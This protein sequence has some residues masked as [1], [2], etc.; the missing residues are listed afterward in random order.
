MDYDVVVVGCGVA[1]LS[2]ALTAVEEGARVAVLER[3]TKDIRGGNS[4]YTEAFMRM[5]N[6]TEISEDFEER[7]VNSSVGCID[8]K[9]VQYTLKPYEKWPPMLRAYGFTDPGIIA[10]FAEGVPPVVQ[11]LK[12]HGIKFMDTAPFLTQLTQRIAPSGGGEAIVEALASVAE[13]QGVTFYYET[14]ARSLIRG[15]KGEV[16]GVHA[17]SNTGGARDFESKAVVLGCGGF[18]GN[19]EM[20][21][22]YVGHHAHLTRPTASGG[23]Y[24]KGEGIEMALAVGA[25]VS[26][27]WDAFHAEPVDPR[28]P[29]PEAAILVFNYGI[30]VN[31]LGQR[32]ID[33]ASGLSDVIYEE[34]SRAILRQPG[35]I[36]YAIYDSKIEDVPNYK[37]QIRSDRSPIRAKSVKELARKL[38]VDPAALTTTIRDF[39]AAV[40]EG[41]F[42]PLNLDGKCTKGI[43]PVKSNWCRPIDE[44]DLISYPIMCVNTFTF[45]GLKT[46]SGAE[47]VNRD[48]YVIPGLYAAGEI[49]GMYYGPYVGSTSVLK[50]LVF[51]KK[52]GKNAGI[53]C[54]QA[55]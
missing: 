3:S 45:G 19:L 11:W 31:K 33:E 8:P 48:G 25:A 30:L 1:G 28:S 36:A 17:W 34:I 27:Q 16:S 51:G 39:N 13:Q 38:E 14:T 2:A 55:S 50:G 42:E 18:E 32:F 21:T 29:Q 26:G 52:A 37:L 24:N 41:N 15:K 54:K 22:R 40:Q 43:E 23:L 5:P 44:E 46:T 35:G 6:E 4:R 9:L 47:V 49:V 7:L 10:A 53:Y 20:M 12:E